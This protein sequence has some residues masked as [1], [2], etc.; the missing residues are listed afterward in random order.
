MKKVLVMIDGTQR[1]L[2]A[3]RATVLEGR[4]C[5]ERIELANVQPLWSKH[6]ARWI[7]RST[8]DAW[9]AERSAAA[10]EPARRFMES[11]TSIPWRAHAVAGPAAATI[12]ALARKLGCSEVVAAPPPRLQRLALPA[13]LGL[14]ALL[15]FADQ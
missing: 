7:P 9:R 14:V 6:V 11:S 10:L 2:D 8:R 12:D 4:G 3:L 15:F 5:I 13:G 1:S